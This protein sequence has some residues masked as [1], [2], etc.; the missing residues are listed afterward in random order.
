MRFLVAVGVIMNAIL[1]VW[2]Q[3][4]S[5]FPQWMTFVFSAAWL[6]LFNMISLIPIVRM[7]YLLIFLALWAVFSVSYIV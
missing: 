4:M 5:G 1:L 2:P 7:V 3:S 6:Y